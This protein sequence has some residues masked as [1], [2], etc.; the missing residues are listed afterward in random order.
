MLLS[1]TDNRRNI[2]NLAARRGTWLWAKLLQEEYP[3][4]GYFM[5][6]RTTPRDVEALQLRAHEYMRQQ[7]EQMDDWD[8][9]FYREWTSL[10][11]RNALAFPYPMG[12]PVGRESEAQTLM[13][14]PIHGYAGGS[15]A[16]T[17]TP[18]QE[19]HDSSPFRTWNTNP[20]LLPMEGT[21]EDGTTTSE[22]IQTT[23]AF[24]DW[25]SNAKPSGTN[26][27]GCDRWTTALHVSRAYS[28]T[29]GISQ[30]SR[31]PTSFPY[32][33][34]KDLWKM[35]TTTSGSTQTTIASRPW[36][37]QHPSKGY[38]CCKEIG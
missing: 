30:V 9:A 37:S 7:V 25:N 17:D 18:V 8:R 15:A 23:P 28:S 22:S 33:H 5:N 29:D 1:G 4:E 13:A 20:L 19:F 14:T 2:W 6:T 10:I 27:T 34:G 35:E 26:P 21:L 11:T 24:Q 36:N 31:N 3:S 32:R 16:S 38:W 12:E